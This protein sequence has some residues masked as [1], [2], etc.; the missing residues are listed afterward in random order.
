MKIS[1]SAGYGLL[2]IGY[3]MKHRDEGIVLSQTISKKYNIPLEYLLKILQQLV[4][5]NVLR[6]KRGPNGG[7][8][9]T[10]TPRKITMLQV[11]EAVDGSMPPHL[12]LEDVP[13]R[14]FSTKA[15]QT[16]K[17][18]VA[19]VISTFEKTKIVDLV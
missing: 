10:K 19:Q 9:L 15:L 3:I 7:F 17:K 12:D 11:I 16:Y 1:R 18:A 8:S 13:R 4:R 2:A 5:A 6:S 14:K